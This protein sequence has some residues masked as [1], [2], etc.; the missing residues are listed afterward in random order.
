MRDYSI[1]VNTCDAYSDLWEP[2]LYLLWFNWEESKKKNIYF[3]TET[4]NKD[5]IAENVCFINKKYEKKDR[6]G[7]R[8]LHSLKNIDS[9]Y[10]VVLMDDFFLRKKVSV[11][12]LSIALEAMERDKH[13]ACFYLIDTLNQDK[14]DGLYS[15]YTEVPKGKNYRLNSAPA[16]WRKASLIRYTEEK[17]NPWA[18]EY[19]GSCRTN[20]TNEKFY[21]VSKVREPVYD[22]AHVVYRGQWLGKDILPLL[23][24]Y[25]LN[26]DF[27][28]R[29]IIRI[30]EKL[31]KRSLKWKM[32]FI[33]TGFRMVGF[34]AFGP[35]FNDLKGKY[36]FR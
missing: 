29:E 34:D 21:A 22:Y 25:S 17:D 5:T 13:I 8:L 20:R 18:W 27:N 12:K 36:V 35:I 28:K 3:N 16:I 30:G 19:F 6:W 9:D 24:Q 2:F 11:E 7:G 14:E 31:P 10:V 4:I 23:Q 15:G 32:L 33:L 26:V 1:L